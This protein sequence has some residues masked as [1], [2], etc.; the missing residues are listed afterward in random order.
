MHISQLVLLR[1]QNIYRTVQ[2]KEMIIANLSNSLTD[3]F[4]VGR[5]ATT[6]MSQIYE[7]CNC[8]MHFLHLNFA[9]LWCIAPKFSLQFSEFFRLCNQGESNLENFGIFKIHDTFLKV[10]VKDIQKTP[11]VTV[12]YDFENLKFKL[13]SNL[14]PIVVHDS[15]M[16]QG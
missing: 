3:L 4:S 7:N 1:C 9:P 2:L 14:I 11:T 13:F 5:A 15:G 10:L 8:F 12:V 6:K 16:T